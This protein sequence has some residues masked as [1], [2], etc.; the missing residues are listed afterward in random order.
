MAGPRFH[1]VDCSFPNSLER[2]DGW[3]TTGAVN[4]SSSSV[5]RC[6]VAEQE[7]NFRCCKVVTLWVRYKICEEFGQRMGLDY[8]F[9]L[10]R[11]NLPWLILCEQIE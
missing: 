5:E 11:S 10:D 6:R 8:V 4:S 7:A 9:A 1:A 2:M 3:K